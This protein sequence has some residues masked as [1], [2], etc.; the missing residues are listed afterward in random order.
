MTVE[1]L[2]QLE[3]RKIYNFF[4][5]QQRREDKT[6]RSAFVRRSPFPSSYDKYS[7]ATQQCRIYDTVK[8][9]KLH[10]RECEGIK[11]P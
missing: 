6:T 1:K 3:V 5:R 4:F 7:P 8:R 10:E 11:E 9:L 2:V